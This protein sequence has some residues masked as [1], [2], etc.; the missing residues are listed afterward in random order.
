MAESQRADSG[1][2]LSTKIVAALE[3]LTQVIRVSQGET[4]RRYGLSPLQLQVLAYVVSRPEGVRPAE[5]ARQFGITPP[6][7]SDA[8]AALVAKKLVRL[9]RV[10]EDGRQRQIRLT[11]KGRRVAEQLGGWAKVVVQQVEKL[12]RFE[13]AQ[14]LEMLLRLIGQLQQA[15]L[16]SVA[17]VCTSCAYFSANVYPDPTAPHHCNLLNQPLAL[18]ELRVDCPDHVLADRR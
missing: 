4:A 17:H 2:A 11:A 15:G 6:T 9:V 7:I 16:I 10:P 3:R 12:D 18:H 5:L 8:L 14:L 1:D 13:Q